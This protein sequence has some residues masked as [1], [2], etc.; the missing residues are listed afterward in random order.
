NVGLYFVIH[1]SL[2]VSITRKES[3]SE[4]KDKKQ[5]SLIVESLSSLNLDSSLLTS[6][7]PRHQSADNK[8]KPQKTQASLFSVEAG[9]LAGYLSALSGYPS[10]VS[11]TAKT[12]TYVGYL[13]KHAVDR[14]TERNPS[15][16]LT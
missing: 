9:G 1:G 10:F 7:G 8:D 11:I 5:K 14:I 6:K 16:L 15:V 3:K 2:D 4:K 13:S 12:D